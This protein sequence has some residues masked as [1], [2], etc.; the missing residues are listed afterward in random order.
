MPASEPVIERLDSRLRT[1][2]TLSAGEFAQLVEFVKTGL[3]DP[4]SLP[5]ELRKLIPATL[6]SGKT[7]HTFQP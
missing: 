1:P 5:V 6:P 7:P 4:R 3:L 2:I